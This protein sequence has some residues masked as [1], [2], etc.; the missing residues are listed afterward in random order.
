[1]NFASETGLHFATDGS[2][3]AQSEEHAY[4]SSRCVQVELP[5]HLYMAC[6]ACMAHM[7]ISV[8]KASKL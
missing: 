5:L 3:N 6:V 8:I 7:Q 2:C 4:S 1:M